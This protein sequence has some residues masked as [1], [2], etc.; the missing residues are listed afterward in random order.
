[1]KSSSR[2]ARCAAAI[3]ALVAPAI[4]HAIEPCV[5]NHYILAEPCSV[6]AIDAAIGSPGAVAVDA[7]GN[8]YFSS[9]NLVFKMDSRGLLTRV[10]GNGTAGYS[11][12][13]GP[14][15]EALLNFP[16]SYYE[17]DAS[18]T[19]YDPLVGPL[20]LDAAGNLYIGDAYNNRVR[21]VDANGVIVT[22]FGD[23]KRAGW[24]STNPARRLWWP[25]GIAIDG[26][27]MLFVSDATGILRRIAPDG[28]LKTMTTNDC[29][30]HEAPGLCNPKGIAA[31]AL[32]NIYVADGYCRVRRVSAAGEGAVKVVTM[33]GADT[34]PDPPCEYSGDNG[35]AIVAALAWPNAVAV[36]AGGT[37]F[38]ADSYNNCIRKVDDAGII[39][40]VAGACGPL[41]SGYS[42]DGGPANEARLANPYGVAVD[43]AGNLY[44]ADRMNQRIRRVTPGGMIYTVAGNGDLLPE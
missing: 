29:G 23:G 1:M 43:A 22:V 10:A 32:G 21:R 5:K 8:V 41:M 7:L 17:M 20:A 40:T 14:A 33:A 27:G 30:S 6:A 9:P 16:K 34:V 25:Q 37:L 42:G 24:G 44:I 11:G 38:I 15:T 4:V 12:D 3:F 28:V 36:D 18:P 31:G 35:P 19:E 26:A 39:T 2:T 13:G